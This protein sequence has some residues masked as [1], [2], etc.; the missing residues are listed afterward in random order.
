VVTILCPHFARPVSATRNGATDKLVD[1]VAKDECA[2]VTT[3]ERGVT[4]T[5]R[6]SACPVFRQPG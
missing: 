5:V 6:P 3:D 2:S 4:V 1:C